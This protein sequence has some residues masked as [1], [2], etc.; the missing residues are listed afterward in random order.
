M[1]FPHYLASLDRIYGA[2]AV[3]DALAQRRA[4]H[5][6]DVTALIGVARDWIGEPHGLGA[7]MCGLAGRAAFAAAAR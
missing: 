1:L 3:D 5:R 6:R 2:H 4:A 7:F